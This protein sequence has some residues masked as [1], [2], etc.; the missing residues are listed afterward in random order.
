ME[1]ELHPIFQQIEDWKGAHGSYPSS[2]LVQQK[3]GTVLQG[4]VFIDIRGIEVSSTLNYLVLTSGN[5]AAYVSLDD[6]A[7]IDLRNGG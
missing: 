6:I 4:H 7:K 1:Q 5:F 3:D 2:A